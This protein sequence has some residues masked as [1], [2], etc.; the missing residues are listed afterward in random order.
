M[1]P[2]SHVELPRRAMSFLPDGNNVHRAR[3]IVCPDDAGDPFFANV[4]LLIGPYGRDTANPVATS[5]IDYSVNQYTVQR[6]TNASTIDVQLS[7]G[8]VGGG[9]F[10]ITTANGWKPVIGAAAPLTLG[11][12]DFTVE[13]WMR[14]ENTPSIGAAR[15]TGLALNGNTGGA[16]TTFWLGYANTGGWGPYNLAMP[17]FNAQ[18]MSIGTLGTA[19]PS[20]VWIYLAVTRASGFVR[21]YQ[22]LE[23]D[24]ACNFAGPTAIGSNLGINTTWGLGAGTSGDQTGIGIPPVRMAGVRITKGVAR[25]TSPILAPPTAPWPTF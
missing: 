18:A 15:Y 19:P 6:C 16:Y 2:P 20:N 11:T 21:M 8:P 24:A 13:G 22:A 14:F 5:C 7:N 12:G 25:Y 1:V 3:N 23:G 4:S 9:C 17:T 10:R